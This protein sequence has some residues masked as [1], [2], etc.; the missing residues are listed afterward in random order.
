MIRWVGFCLFSAIAFSIVPE[1]RPLTFLRHVGP[2]LPADFQNGNRP[3]FI[4][5]DNGVWDIGLEHLKFF[6]SEHG[7]SYKEIK[8][9]DIKA[10]ILRAEVPPLLVMPGGE[11]WVYLESLGDEGAEKILS[12]VRGGGAYLGI[13]AGAFYATSHR[14]GG[15]ETGEYGIG[16]L[17]GVAYDG[18]ALGAPS[19]VD[20][21]M[22]FSILSSAI[23]TGIA[24]SLKI[25]MFG[26][27][28][29]RFSTL[30]ATSK[31]VKVLARFKLFKEP[32][33]IAFQ[34]GLGRAFLS[35]PHFEV[36]E[37]RTDWTD[38]VDPDSEWP[39]FDRVTCWLLSSC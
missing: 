1:A 5:A 30:E 39:L 26:G 23:T 17:K 18:T 4:Y 24:S 28:S 32:G 16:L 33:M 29:F 10:G 35:G 2:K 6:F 25:A 12:Y 15:A 34:Y 14:E 22:D 8:A 36:E 37:P 27:P 3:V 7:Y 38:I 21:M 9:A 19:F 20:G 13:C 11:S 31:K